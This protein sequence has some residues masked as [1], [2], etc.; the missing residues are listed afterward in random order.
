M[1]FPGVGFRA[2]DRSMQH[3]AAHFSQAMHIHQ[4]F[5]LDTHF[6]VARR[7]DTGDTHGGCRK[8]HAL[9]PLELAQA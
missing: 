7:F 9:F 1:L 5:K 8:T 6:G 4:H 3:F 2:F